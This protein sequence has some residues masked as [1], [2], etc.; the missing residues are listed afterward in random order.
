[1]LKIPPLTQNGRVFRLA[2]LGM[3]HLGSD[4]KGA[5]FAKVEVI[6]PAELSPEE[7]ELFEKLK[8]AQKVGPKA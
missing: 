7:R 5:L 4:A 2:G 3:P 6:L 8:K 1:M